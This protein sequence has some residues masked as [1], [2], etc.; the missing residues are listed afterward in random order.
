MSFPGLFR[1]VLVEVGEWSGG[2]PQLSSFRL[3]SFL[4]PWIRETWSLCTVLLHLSEPNLVQDN[5]PVNSRAPWTS[6][7]KA[8]SSG[9]DVVFCYF[10]AFLICFLQAPLTNH[11]LNILASYSVL[12]PAHLG[13]SFIASNF[14]WRWGFILVKVIFVSIYLIFL[15]FSN[16][17]A[18]SSQIWVQ[19][20]AFIGK[21]KFVPILLAILRLR[22]GSSVIWVNY[23]WCLFPRDFK[24]A[25]VVQG[26]R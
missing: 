17:T 23:C 24:V 12:W 26:Q 9:L 6:S 21:L 5:F 10:N 11:S 15:K 2:L 19:I 25:W 3:L 20:S 18:C 16:S 4:W 22:K 8:D 13:F 14:P 1:A 7:F